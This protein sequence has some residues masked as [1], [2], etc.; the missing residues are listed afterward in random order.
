METTAKET[1][2]DTTT[3]TNY[4]IQL[5][6]AKTKKVLFLHTYRP[7][8]RAYITTTRFQSNA[9]K[10]ATD[11]EA[12]EFIDKNAGYFGYNWKVVPT[13]NLTK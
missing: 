8:L 10:F 13:E 6:S 7:G 11:G 9:R 5:T 12:Q 3:S 1:I 2:M 4:A